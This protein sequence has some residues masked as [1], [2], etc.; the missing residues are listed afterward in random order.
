MNDF[1]DH[2]KKHLENPTFAAEWKRQEPEREYIKA[3][4]SAR[5]EQNMTQEEL[6]RVLRK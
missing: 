3:I 6:S 1:K 2:L 4:V 5:I